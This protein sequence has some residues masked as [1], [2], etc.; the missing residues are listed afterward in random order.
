MP[1]IV[2]NPETATPDSHNERAGSARSR[3]LMYGAWAL[4]AAGLFLYAQTWAFTDDEGF[5]LLAAQL[6]KRGLRP[7]L[8]FCF[9]QTPFNAY[10]N[11]FWMRLFGESWRTAHALA[12]LET[13]AAVLLA[14]QF[15]YERLPERPWRVAGAIAAAVVIGC[16]SNLVEFGPLG[17]AYGIC[18]FSAVSAFRLAVA[19][20]DRRDWQAAAGAGVFAGVAAASSLLS[21]MV[22]PVLLIWFGWCNR[23]GKRWSKVLAFAIGCTIPFLPL[24]RL[25]TRSPRVV[26][27]NVAQYHMQYRVVYW[28]DPLRHDLETITAWAGEPQSL[29]LGLLAIFGVV[30]IARRSGWNRE[31][32]D[33]FYL[34]GWLALG[35]A[36][37]LA[38]AHPTFA[39][40]FCLLAPFVGILAVPGLYALGSRVLSPERPFWPVLI[41]CVISGGALARTLYNDRTLSTWPEYEEMARKVESVTPP[42]K[43]IFTEEQIYFLTKRRPPHGMEFG[44]SHKLK[45]PPERMS[46]L[47]IVSEPELQ[48]EVS[49]G[50]FGSAA[51]CDNDFVNTYGLDKAF[52]QKV[53]LH[54]CSVYWD[55]QPA[56]E[57]AK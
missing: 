7:Y 10:W 5:H 35:I 6:I 28:P 11:A 40:Y 15:V 26:W 42:G 41:I 9:P 43:Q 1:S 27:F 34:C 25:F 48:H 54:N 22:A 13:A 37:E 53:D 56:T 14:T 30:Y 31:R 44:Y 29:L 50:I 47:N 39:R 18:L 57:E 32:R 4:I 33:E 36:A 19:G 20:A 55:W 52:R 23:A 21:V 3:A 2:S 8:D 45:F 38:F 12:A 16:N 51:T 24:V 49:A 17:Q 46:A